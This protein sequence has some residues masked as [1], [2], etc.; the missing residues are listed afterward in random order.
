[1]I[2]TVS[3]Q[4]GSLGEE[5]I[6]LLGQKLGMPVITRKLVM[7]EWFPAIASKH[8]LHMLN[9][10]PSYFLTDSSSGISFAQHLENLLKDFTADQDAIIF[11]MGAQI[12]YANDP[13]ALHIKIMASR[14]VLIKR[15]IAAHHL[16]RQDAERFL[17]LTDRKHKRYISSIYGQDWA[18]PALYDI[19][20]NTD[21]IGIDEAAAL[22]FQMVEYRRNAV[23]ADRLNTPNEE[24]PAV[25]F[26]HP[27]EEEFARILDMHEIEWQYEPRTFPVK[28]DA[29]GNV[30]QAFS[31]DFYLPRFNTFIEITTMDQKYVSEKKKKVKLLKKLY[32]GTNINIVFKNDFNQLVKR[33]KLYD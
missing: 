26:K 8:E 10:S 32:P 17:E 30:I 9:E 11:G 28:W 2:I 3:R 7:N 16:D 29:E 27:S 33:F 20:L 14:D 13:D 24:S 23:P 4:T 25:D 22:I 21:M 15:I 6:A 1:M 19:T 18:D 5:I 31:P 12:I